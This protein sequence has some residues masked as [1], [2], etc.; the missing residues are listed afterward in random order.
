MPPTFYLGNQLKF[1][2]FRSYVTIRRHFRIG[3]R[4]R[5]RVFPRQNF[6]LKTEVKSSSVKHTDCL[7]SR[8]LCV[9]LSQVRHR[10]FPVQSKCY[11]TEIT[12]NVTK[13]YHRNVQIYIIFIC[14]IYSIHLYANVHIMSVSK[15]NSIKQQEE[16]I[17]NNI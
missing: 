11:P 16:K 5:R 10:S 12:R 4:Q 2:L 3:L 13:K 8:V 17:D 9:G 15:D 6:I 7:C 1:V 14:S